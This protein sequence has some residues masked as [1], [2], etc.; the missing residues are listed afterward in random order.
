MDEIKPMQLSDLDEIKRWSVEHQNE[1]SLLKFKELFPIETGLI[2]SGV[3]AGFLFLTETKVAYIDGL[4]S[5]PALDK[6]FRSDCLDALCEALIDLA[7]YY[8]V[9]V[10]KCDTNL[11][12]VQKRVL[13]YGFHQLGNDYKLFQ[14]ELE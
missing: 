13:K 7:K 1:I 10:L 4:I 11:L 14:K 2:M 12:H 9:K 3:C 6:E 8:Q 5:N